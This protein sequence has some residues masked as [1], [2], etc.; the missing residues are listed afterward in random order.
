MTKLLFAGDTLVEPAHQRL[1]VPALAKFIQAHDIACCNLE[2]PLPGD[3]PALSKVGPTLAQAPQT[4]TLLIEAGFTIA[5]LANNHIADYGLSGIT[6]TIEGL[7]E[8]V[9]VGADST[10]NGAYALRVITKNNT[11]FGFLAF[12]EWGFGAA[13]SDGSGGFAWIFHPHALR[14]VEAARREVDVLIVSVHA[15]VEAADLPLPEWRA[16]YHELV[17]AGANI[18]VGH[19]PHRLQGWE[20][21]QQGLIFYSL[22]NFIFPTKRFGQRDTSGAFLSLE[23]DGAILTAW[24]LVPLGERDGHLVMLEDVTESQIATM[25]AKLDGGYAA[26]IDA[27][28]LKLWEERYCHLYERSLGGFHTWRG[29]AR[30]GRNLFLG[31][32][33]D[34]QL[35]AHNLG[36][37]SHHFV[38]RRAALLLA[39]R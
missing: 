32:S 19:H 26:A 23:Y 35:L 9:T 36:I 37:E 6:A 17:T 10:W 15:G 8:I 5:T 11:R 18:I 4:P 27:L 39:K 2:G 28:V 24:R 20:Q 14:R 13:D 21:S 25:T 7:R 12:A 3:G 30:A 16:R 38:A 29:A 31:H 22:G 1:V 34:Y 33:T